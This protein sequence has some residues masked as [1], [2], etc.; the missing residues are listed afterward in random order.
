MYEE[1]ISIACLSNMEPNFLCYSY[2]LNSPR[3]GGGGV[4]GSTVQIVK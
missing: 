1:Q 3:G 4:L 2:L